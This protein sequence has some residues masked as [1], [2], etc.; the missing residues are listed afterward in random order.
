[1]NVALA[2][3]SSV[4]GKP[5]AHMLTAAD[6]TVTLCHTATK[7]TADIFRRSGMIVSAAGRAKWLKKEM[8][9]NGAI[10]IDVGTNLDDRGKMCGDAD[11]DGVAAAAAAVTPV[12][13]GVGP[14]TKACLLEA[15]VKAAERTITEV[16]L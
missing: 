6:A 4:V 13:G 11:Y 3:R 2:G 10:I 9:P 8:I 15:A 12:P 7:D 16:G 5:L 14:V 1:M